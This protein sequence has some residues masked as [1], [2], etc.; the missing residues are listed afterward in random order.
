MAVMLPLTGSAAMHVLLMRVSLA[1]DAYEVFGFTANSVFTRVEVRLRFVEHGRALNSEHWMSRTRA[2]RDALY[3][4]VLGAFHRI[5]WSLDI[6][7]TRLDQMD[8]QS[9]GET[10]AEA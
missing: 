6:I 8:D 4:F 7:A 5:L 2:V 1:R 3:P 10:D 9:G